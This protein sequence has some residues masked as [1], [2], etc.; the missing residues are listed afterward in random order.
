MRSHD[1]LIRHYISISL[2]ADM[3]TVIKRRIPE[4]SCSYPGDTCRD[5]PFLFTVYE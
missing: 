1:M 2:Q 5:F 3:L 4:T